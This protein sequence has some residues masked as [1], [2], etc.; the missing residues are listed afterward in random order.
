MK[1]L[2]QRVVSGIGKRI[3]PLALAG[4]GIIGCA[5]YSTPLKPSA[6]LDSIEPTTSNYSKTDMTNLIDLGNGYFAR[7][8]KAAW[9]ID[10]IN[11]ALLSEVILKKTDNG[12]NKRNTGLYSNEEIWNSTFDQSCKFADANKDYIL[13]EDEVGELLDLTYES[14]EERKNEIIWVEEE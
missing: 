7:T 10:L 5:T 6:E 8:D 1:S 11:S 3:I 4:A 12:Y 13:E 14:I 9:D 2:I